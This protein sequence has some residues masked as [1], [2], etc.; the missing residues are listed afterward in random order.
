[1]G[2]KTFIKMLTKEFRVSFPHVFEMSTFGKGKP[3]F[4]IVMLFPK[5]TTDL[6]EMKAAATKCAQDF[7]GT[8]LPEY[9]ESPIKN[10]DKK[11]DKQTGE[12]MANFKGM[13]Y[14][15]AKTQMKP[16]IVQPDGKTY[17]TDPAAFYAGCWARA[18]VNAFA[19][20]QPGKAGVSFGLQN[21]QK[22][23]DDVPF[24]ARTKAEDDFEP[25]E[26]GDF[27]DPANYEKKPDDP[28]KW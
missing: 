12:V 15:T 18:T 26:G 20:E 9:L 22:L 25:V 21:V 17:I 6:S 4:N 5:A 10:G 7:W 16:G 8:K 11:T 14:V 28:F 1:M 27:N 2:T 3:S 19:W 23:R 24:S 13:W